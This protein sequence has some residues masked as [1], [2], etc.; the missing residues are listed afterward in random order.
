MSRNNYPTNR[1]K[2]QAALEEWLLKTFEAVVTSGNVE[3][4]QTLLDSAQE[5][6]ATEKWSGMRKWCREWLGADPTPIERL[7]TEYPNLPQ[8]LRTEEGIQAI[9]NYP[10]EHAQEVADFHQKLIGLRDLTL[11]ISMGRL[12][13]GEKIR[14]RF[15]S[16]VEG[17]FNTRE[18]GDGE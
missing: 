8:L 11:S 2:K 14:A 3:P 6:L 13:D 12:R 15:R 5:L 18:V 4:R 7:A 16:I 17:K 10:K 9:L 1:P